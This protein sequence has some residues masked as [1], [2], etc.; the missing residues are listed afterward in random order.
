[1]CGYILLLLISIGVARDSYKAIVQPV[2]TTDILGHKI[3]EILM[4]LKVGH[5]LIASGVAYEFV[6]HL[7]LCLVGH[8]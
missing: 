6:N 2:I 1:M 3:N 8:P 4:V 7:A 5:E